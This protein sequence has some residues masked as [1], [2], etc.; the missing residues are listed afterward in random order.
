[1]YGFSRG[2]VGWVL[3]VYNTTKEKMKDANIDS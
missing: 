1:M 3:Q 2:L